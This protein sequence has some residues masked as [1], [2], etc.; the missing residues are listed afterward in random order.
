[1]RVGGVAAVAQDRGQVGLGEPARLGA[2]AS[3]ASTSSVPYTA[4]NST[5][6]SI[7][8][9]TLP[10]PAAAALTS[11]AATPGPSARNAAS[12]GVRG[13]GVWSRIREVDRGG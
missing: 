10:V 4:A 1:M 2:T 3:A 13:F 7:L 6:W 8:T 5:A 12:P 9:R 11:H